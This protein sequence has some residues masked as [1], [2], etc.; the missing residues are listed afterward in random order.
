MSNLI[1]DLINDEKPREKALKYGFSSLTDVELLAI[2]LRTGTKNLSAI[3]LSREIIKQF[4][5]ISNLKNARLET[6]K[7][8]NGIGKVKAISILTCLELSKRI[9]WQN[10]DESI[11]IKESQD[12]FDNFQ[13][14]FIDCEQEIFYTLFLNSKNEVINKKKLFIGTVNQSFVHPRDI[15]KEAILNNAVKIICIHNH[16]TG[17]VMPSMAD[18]VFTKKIKQVG[19]LIGIILID[20]VIIGYD[21]YF[22]FLENRKDIWQ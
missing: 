3:D 8:I 13:H 2:I 20:H 14:L 16:P 7:N 11:Q 22:S 5:T 12:V 18:E 9:K 1:K 21:K 4:K 6:L 10:K 17:N 19:D 15:F